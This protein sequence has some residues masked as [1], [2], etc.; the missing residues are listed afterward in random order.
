MAPVDAINAAQHIA[1]LVTRE[2]GL[3][4]GFGGRRDIRVDL[5][6]K[7]EASGGVYGDFRS[8]SLIGSDNSMTWQWRSG[9]GSGISLPDLV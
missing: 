7:F 4:F 1:K 2:L 9:K 5:R 3:G 8:D 6:E